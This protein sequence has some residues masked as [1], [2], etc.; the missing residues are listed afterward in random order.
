MEKKEEEDQRAQYYIDWAGKKN[1]MKKEKYVHPEPTQYHD[2]TVG[3]LDKLREKRRVDGVNVQVQFID[4][5]IN[6]PNLNEY[7][8]LHV[9]RQHAHFLESKAKR[10]EFVMKHTGNSGVDK[11]M[12]VNDMYLDAITAKLKLLDKI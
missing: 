5:M 2:T 6:D 10:D 7:D 8:R 11:E 3:Y 4:R 12:E 1:S 9:V